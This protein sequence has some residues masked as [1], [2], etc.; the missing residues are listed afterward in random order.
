MTS[1][2]G[3]VPNELPGFESFASSLEDVASFVWDNQQTHQPGLGG[4]SFQATSHNGGNELLWSN[5]DHSHNQSIPFGSNSTSSLCFGSAQRSTDWFGSDNFSNAL[6]DDL[7]S[8]LRSTEHSSLSGE[9]GRGRSIAQRAR[10][11]PSARRYACPEP[12]CSMTFQ[13]PKDLARHQSTVHDQARP[14]KCPQESCKYHIEGF[15]RLDN[16]ARHMKNMHGR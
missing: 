5:I 12:M 16:R 6:E 9:H 10:P 14:F 11:G 8:F 7:R 2:I 1:N 3:P 13:Y 4:E 15:G